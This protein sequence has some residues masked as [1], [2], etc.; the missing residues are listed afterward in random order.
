MWND[1]RLCSYNDFIHSP[2]KHNDCLVLYTFVLAAHPPIKDTTTTNATGT[3][4]TNNN[5]QKD[6]G[7]Y[8]FYTQ[9]N[10]DESLKAVEEAE[11]A[12]P[13]TTDTEK[14]KDSSEKSESSDSDKPSQTSQKLSQ[15][16]ES[17]ST[18]SVI[19]AIYDEKHVKVEIS[20]KEGEAMQKDMILNVV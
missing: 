17:S 7:D 3:T 14:S 8:D 16:S 12:K 4:T 20:K 6:D 18:A 2:S 10:V 19:P 5:N 11:K 1:K 13:E 9:G 15:Q